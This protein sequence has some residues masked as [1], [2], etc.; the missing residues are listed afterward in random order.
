MTRKDCPRFARPLRS[1]G[2]PAPDTAGNATRRTTTVLNTGLGDDNVTVNLSAGQDGFLVLNTAGGA[3]IPLSAVA[4]IKLQNGEG[5][6]AHE[7]G[8]RNVRAMG[9]QPATLAGLAGLGDLVL[10]CTGELSRNR[11]VGH[12]D[13]V[14]CATHTAAA[15]QGWRSRRERDRSL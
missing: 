2:R 13:A 7:M 4:S 15:C 10:T 9:G 1:S 12:A 11:S 8:R 3:Q 5:T 6:I 14:R